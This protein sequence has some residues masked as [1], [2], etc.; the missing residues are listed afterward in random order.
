MQKKRSGKDRWFIGASMKE[1]KVLV[2]SCGNIDSAQIKSF[3][4]SQNG[5][6]AA[7]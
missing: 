4:N 2:D 6:I 5:T 7:C 3:V 1:S